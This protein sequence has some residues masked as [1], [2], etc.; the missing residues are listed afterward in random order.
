MEKDSYNIQLNL[1][2]IRARL[3]SISLAWV[4][5]FNS[6]FS[7]LFIRANNHLISDPGLYCSLLMY[8]VHSLK[9]FFIVIVTSDN[10]TIHTY[11]K[12]GGGSK[13][14]TTVNDIFWTTSYS[15]EFWQ[16]C[17]PEHHRLVSWSL[18][19]PLAKMVNWEI[20]QIPWQLVAGVPTK[21]K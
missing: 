1:C 4:R 10:S 12:G 9:W 3:Y 7:W 16:W 17:S 11:T 21:F 8:P 2:N 15:I 13:S 5:S 6:V 18:Y 14:S 20:T 19:L